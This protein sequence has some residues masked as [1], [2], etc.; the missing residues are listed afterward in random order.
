MCS[1]MILQ[2]RLPDDQQPR[3]LPGV[4]PLAMEA[5]LQVDDAYAGQMAERLRILRDHREK[6]LKQDPSAG[7]AARELLALVLSQL[8]TREDFRVDAGRVVCPDGHE[9][10]L[11]T[12]HPLETLCH[13][14]QEDFCLLD[15]QGA[16]HVLIAG[17]LCFPASWRLDQKFLRPLGAIHAPVAEYDGAMAARVQRLF[18]GVKPG[19]PLWR[20]NLL[21]YRDA[22]LY[23]PR[24]EEAPRPATDM[25]SAPFLRSE[26]QSILRLPETGVV[27]FSIHTCVVAR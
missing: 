19:R 20:S 23:Q 26:R 12:A 6:V 9:V 24:A 14:V 2:A 10:Q 27:V 5:W 25:S 15:K 4:Q 18:D 1:V 21:P 3:P 17:L 16:E 11:D 13:L 22:A 8:G 7:P